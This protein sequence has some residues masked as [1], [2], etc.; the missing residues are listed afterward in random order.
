MRVW[1]HETVIHWFRFFGRGDLGIKRAEKVTYLF[2]YHCVVWGE[3]TRILEYNMSF[4]EMS[5]T[6]SASKVGYSIF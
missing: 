5:L 2:L 3:L 4:T 1:N 6:F